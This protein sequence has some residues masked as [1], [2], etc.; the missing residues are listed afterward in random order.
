MPFRSTW[1]FAGGLA[2]FLAWSAL[3]ASA[4]DDDDDVI[5]LEEHVPKRWLSDAPDRLP[6]QSE[7]WRKRLPKKC[8]TRGGYR[9]YCQGMRRV[10]TPSGPDAHE[11]ER[12]GLGHRASAM[13]LRLGRALPEWLE[14]AKGDSMRALTWPVPGGHMGRGF[15]R[16][17]RASLRHRKHLGI[18][19][20]AEERTPIVAARGGIVI[21]S[22]DTLTGY[23]NSV[24][25][26]H[27]DDSTTFYAHCYANLVFAGQRVARGQIIAEVGKTGFAPAPHLH[28]EWRRRG[29]AKNPAKH[30]LRR[31][32]RAP[33]LARTTP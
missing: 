18:D 16:V 17:R 33:R 5:R 6:L 12:L 19:I 26:L 4:D 10:P 8:R 30:F 9:Q 13:K 25:I 28:F 23:G 21:Y 7:R 27:E 15:G 14:A 3:P 32:K 1:L 31:T 11:A 22:D 24:M 20:G 2:A 29:H